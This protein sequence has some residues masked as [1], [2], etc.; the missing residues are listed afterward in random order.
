MTGLMVDL[1][2]DGEGCLEGILSRTGASLVNVLSRSSSAKREVGG[3]VL[4]EKRL[5]VGERAD[6]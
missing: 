2:V 1:D 6:P 5:D 3:E 4:E